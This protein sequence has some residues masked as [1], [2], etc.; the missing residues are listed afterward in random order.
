VC[1]SDLSRWLLPGASIATAAA[2]LL[3]FVFLRSPDPQALPFGRVVASRQPT[4]LV[5]RGEATSQWLQQEIAGTVAPRFQ[6]IELVG[7]NL[8][9]ND[10]GRKAARLVYEVETSGTR[11]IRL[12]A[13]L[14]R[15]RPGE[16]DGG[17]QYQ[18]QGRIL[19][20]SE[21][22]GQPA[23]GFLDENGIGYVFISRDLSESALF[24]LVC[25]SD[26]IDRARHA[27]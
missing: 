16:F 7:G 1:S 18:Y 8:T 12:E 13:F 27:R 10:E 15:A 23:V 22:A 9:T 26:L 6:G 3:V 20:V 25:S 24:D 17:R 5:A 2:A 19:H 4:A 11:P 21:V 14:F